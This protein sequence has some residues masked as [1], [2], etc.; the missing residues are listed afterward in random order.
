LDTEKITIN[1]SVVDLG[2]IDL[3][4][5]E[6]FYANRTDFIRTAIRMQLG[7]HDDEVKSSASRRAMAIG[8]LIYDRKELEAV[9]ATGKRLR[10]SMVGMLI[11]NDNVPPQLAV[12]TIEYVKISGVF[13]ASRA[14]KDALAE[15]I[16]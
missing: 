5:E 11:I 15:R 9:R 1:L 7:R 4:V 6:G 2:K 16:H 8:V 10:I 3:L 12:D 14:V 13:R